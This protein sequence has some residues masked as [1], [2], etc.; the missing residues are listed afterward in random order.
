MYSYNLLITISIT[1]EKLCIKFS[2]ILTRSKKFYR[3][4][5]KKNFQKN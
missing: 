2:S 4:F 3:H 1:N 5:K